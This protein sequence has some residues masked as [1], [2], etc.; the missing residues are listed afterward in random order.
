MAAVD[1]IHVQLAKLIIG[2]EG[3][4]NGYCHWILMTH[5]DDTQS[6]VISAFY[7]SVYYYSR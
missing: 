2:G 1:S 6:Q 5:V 7:T 3:L 4:C